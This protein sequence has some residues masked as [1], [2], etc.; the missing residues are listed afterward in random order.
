MEKDNFELYKS[1]MRKMMCVGWLHRTTFER[2]I[3]KLGIHHSQHYILVYIA[4]NKEIASQKMIAEHCGITPAAVAR[5]LK[6]LETEGYI[7]RAN[8]ENDSRFKKIVITDKGREIVKKTHQMFKEVDESLFADFSDED[9]AAFNEYLDKMQ[10]RLAEKNEENCFV[11][12]KDEKK[13]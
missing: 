11:R 13:Q 8:V 7:E 12:K 6:T 3:S 5:S 9:I 2:N 4:K 1:T 10:A